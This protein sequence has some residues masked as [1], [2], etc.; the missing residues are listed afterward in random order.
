MNN[1]NELYQILINLILICEGANIQHPA[2]DKA[3]SYVLVSNDKMLDIILCFVRS[4]S[5][6]TQFE[7]NS[8]GKTTIVVKARR[9]YFNLARE[10]TKRS[11]SE[12][13]RKVSRDHSTVL[14]GLKKMEEFKEIDD[15]EW[16]DYTNYNKLFS[17]QL[18]TRQNFEAEETKLMK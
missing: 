9:L 3:K 14:Y 12:I 6:V 16:K 7:L 8:K 18:K 15:Y 11:L 2:V 17:L 13:G 1:L 10:H 4:V 5:N